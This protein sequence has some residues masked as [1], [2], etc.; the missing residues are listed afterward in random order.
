MRFKIAGLLAALTVIAIGLALT[1]QRPFFSVVQRGYRGTAMVQVINNADA[2][3]KQYANQLPEPVASLDPVG[4]TAASV[5][6]NVKVLGDVDAADFIRIMNA[7]TSWVAPQQGCGYCHDLNDLASDSLYTKV[8]ARRMI[9]MVR[10]VNSDWKTHVAMTGVTC[11][12]CHRGQPV[13]ANIWFTDPGPETAGGALGNKAGQNAP[14]RSPGLSSLP[15]DPYT[16][17]LNQDD[18][19]RVVSLTALPGEDHKSIKQTE[20]TYA[21][22][23]HMSTALGVNC[24]FC[25]NTRS[26]ADWS[27][28]TPQRV[29]AW[30]GI[31]MVRDLNMHYLDPLASTFPATRLGPTGDGPKLNCA[32]CH[33][34]AYKP[35]F[36]VSMLKDFP[37]LAS[38]AAATPAPAPAAAPEPPPAPAPK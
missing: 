20:W 7:M 16:P 21:L 25:H 33:Q 11:Y 19:I 17:F 38:E 28:S 3:A 35:L 10:H 12:T 22:M 34:G 6:S 13:P 32:T 26:F 4:Q 2:A 29:T 37:A 14:L 15:F 30:Y 8:V 24:T 18:E 5:Y 1:F 31:R 23:M 27:Q 36:G 9:Q